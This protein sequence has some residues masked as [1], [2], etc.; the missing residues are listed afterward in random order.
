MRCLSLAILS[1]CFTGSLYAQDITYTHDGVLVCIPSVD[2]K[3][4]RADIG[5]EREWRREKL[6][7]DSRTAVDV[8]Y[9]RSQSPAPIMQIVKE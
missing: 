4:K 5:A 1:I 8:S 6:L 7:V 3:D 2:Y 9:N